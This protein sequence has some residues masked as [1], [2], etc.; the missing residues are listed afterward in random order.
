MCRKLFKTTIFQSH[1]RN[2]TKNFQWKVLL[3]RIVAATPISGNPA[4][5][6]GPNYTSYFKCNDC[7]YETDTES[8]MKRHKSNNNEISHNIACETC[9]QEFKGETLLKQHEEED[10]MNNFI[11]EKCGQGFSRETVLKR[12][13]D[14]GHEG[15]EHFNCDKCSF[16]TTT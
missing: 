12:H 16:Q 1:R 7:Q 10:H 4:W 5:E 2:H 14:E 13:L 9:G 11:C 8:G 6:G 3:S 15:G